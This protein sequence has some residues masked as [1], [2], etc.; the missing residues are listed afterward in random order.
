MPNLVFPAL[1]FPF[2]SRCP[3]PPL[4][5]LLSPPPSR[6]DIPNSALVFL[7]SGAASLGWKAPH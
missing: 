7:F 3:P 4:A 5:L 2:L 1:F 6:Q